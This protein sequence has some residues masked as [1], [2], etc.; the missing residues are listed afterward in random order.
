[1]TKNEKQFLLINL[2]A[3]ESYTFGE[4]D[5]KNILLMNK[6]SAGIKAVSIIIRNFWDYLMSMMCK[7][8]LL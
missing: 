2:T 7:G 1:M 5:N 3:D 4:T 8:R 6:I